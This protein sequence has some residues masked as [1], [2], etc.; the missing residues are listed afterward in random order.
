MGATIWTGICPGT[1]DTRVL[2]CDGTTTLLK[3]RLSPMP[4]HPRALQWF[5]EAVALWQGMPVR[6]VLSAERMDDGYA[7]PLHRDWFPDFGGPLYT[8]EWSERVRR[9]RQRDALDGLG[10]FR[11]LKQLQLFD[12]LE[13]SR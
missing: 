12:V 6:A 1:R 5:L 7:T 2:V 4:A 8:V 3:A 11:D 9:R 10:D 13:S